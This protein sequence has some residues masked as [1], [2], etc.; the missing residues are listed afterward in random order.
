MLLRNQTARFT[1]CE[2]ARTGNLFNFI[3]KKQN[4]QQVKVAVIQKPSAYLNLEKS[5]QLAKTYVEE[6]AKEGAQLI[7]FGETWLSGY[8]SWL[9]H[10][11]EIGIW[12]HQPT[13][14]MFREMY[15]SAVEVPGKASQFIGQLAK[16]HGVWMV[17]GINEKMTTGP[18]NGTLFNTFLIYDS[19][20]NIVNHHRKLMP[21]FTE[22]LLYGTGDAHGLKAVNTPFGKLGGLICWEHWMPLTRQVLH[23]SGE[24]IHIALWPTVHELLQIASRHY[25]FE[26]RCFVIAAGQILRV[27]DVPAHLKRPE[28]LQDKEDFLLLKGGSS[29]IGPDGKYLLE[30]QFD[31]EGIFYAT[32]DLDRIPEEK[33]ALD[34]TGH[35]QRPDIFQMSV[36][37][38]R[39]F[40]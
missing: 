22:K 27:R 8:P 20:G 7:V 38:K 1:R 31:C 34:V 18:A 13:K 2:T 39:F 10:Y 5:L 15:Q 4:M 30:P 35:Y 24:Q 21:T 25:A 17:M 36:N 19:N 32:L 6:A 28:K 9:D 37:R 40:E 23:D 29:I 33:M 3:I 11:P 26:G 14:A 16:E 12:D